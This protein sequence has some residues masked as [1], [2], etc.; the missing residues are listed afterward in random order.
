MTG[1]A[2]HEPAW[3]HID[4]HHSNPTLPANEETSVLLRRP[5]GTAMAITLA[6]L[7]KLPAHEEAGC[8]IGS[9]GHANSGP[10]TFGGVRL[11]D[12]VRAYVG[13]GMAW[14]HADVTSADGY[15]NRVNRTELENP[16]GARTIMLATQID[17]Q[18]MTREQGLVRLIVPDETE[19]ALRQVKWVAR[20]DVH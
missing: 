6:D 3:L 9:T 19:G 12:L 15:G 5:N 4:S 2:G 17:G 18:A 16:P 14:S 10:F 13:D 7:A 20:I 8:R 11:L 1:D